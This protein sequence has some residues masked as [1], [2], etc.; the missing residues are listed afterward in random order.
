MITPK[1]ELRCWQARIEANCRE[2]QRSRAMEDMAFF[3]IGAWRTLP[4]G[5]EVHI[6][7]NEL[8]F[9]RPPRR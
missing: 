7:I 3:G 6:P 5:D 1:I 8:T 2:A 9:L 4:N